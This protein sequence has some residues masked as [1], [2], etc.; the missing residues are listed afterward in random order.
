MDKNE[1]L[2]FADNMGGP[3]GYYANKGNKSD[4]EGQILHDNIYVKYLK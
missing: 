1:I 2:T 3:G 4:K